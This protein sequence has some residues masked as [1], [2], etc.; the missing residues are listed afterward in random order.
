MLTPTAFDQVNKML[1]NLF[2]NIKTYAYPE[3]LEKVL[4]INTMYTFSLMKLMGMI[5][6]ADTFFYL[7]NDD[8][9]KV[10]N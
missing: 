4:V 9:E 1:E 3:R 5:K 10:W 7:C 2:Q 6:T 8:I